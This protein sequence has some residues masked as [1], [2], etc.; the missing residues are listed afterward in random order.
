[1]NAPPDDQPLRTP[2]NRAAA[3]AEPGGGFTLVEMLAVMAVIVILIAVI[4]P[5][6]TT[7]AR[8]PLLTQASDEIVAMFNLAQQSAAA[9]NQTVAVRFYQYAD[10]SVGEST[11]SPNNGR[12]RAAQLFLVND[13]GTATPLRAV[14]TFPL[15]II[16]DSGATLSTL[17]TDNA[18]KKKWPANDP[19]QPS[20]PRAG[21]NYNC[22]E[23][24]F[25]P[26]G[27]TNLL[28]TSNWFVTLHNNLDGDARTTT[29][30]NF[31]TIQI[32]PTNGTSSVYR[33]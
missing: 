4:A 5:A 15:G 19:T 6:F 33:P 25:R 16:A 14:V 29:P 7:M 27:S 13:D 31:S 22:C 23:F 10:A 1:M 20:L 12:Y 32:D 28:P 21:T 9:R 8:G 17:L 11:A 3:S 26:D 30:P 24:R 2:P 18:V